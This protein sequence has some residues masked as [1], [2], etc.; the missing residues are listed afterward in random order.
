MGTSLHLCRKG[1]CRTRLPTSVLKKKQKTNQLLVCKHGQVWKF[2]YCE[3]AAGVVPGFHATSC[4]SRIGELQETLL[5]LGRKKN[6][7]YSEAKTSWDLDG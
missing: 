5:S 2:G 1:Q 6:G 4:V 7:N 3:E